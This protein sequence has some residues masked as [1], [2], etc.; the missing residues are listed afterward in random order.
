MDGASL[1]RH[2]ESFR[3]DAIA[4]LT[5]AERTSLHTLIQAPIAGAV[6]IPAR[7][8]TFVQDWTLPQILPSLDQASAGRDFERGRR[9]FIDT[10]CYACHRLGNAGAAIGPEIGA[11]AS[12]YSRRELLESLV[13][14]SKVISEQYQNVRV[15]L[16]DGEDLIGRI[17]RETDTEVVL[18][19][20]PLTSTEQGVARNLI[21][22]IKPSIVSPMPEGL[23]QV[24]TL[25]DILD[26]LAFLESGGN[27]NAPAF[28]RPPQ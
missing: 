6:L 13:E 2:L 22:E 1:D 23:L 12:K 24:L 16:K 26:M 15:F 4:S 3:R 19:T 5:D 14:P 27:S 25:D 8:R 9:A 21:D 10:Q 7:P 18:E 17:T 20:D 11:L 28:R